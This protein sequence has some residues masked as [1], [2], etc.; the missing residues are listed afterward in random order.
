MN[1]TTKSRKVDRAAVA[2]NLASH[3]ICTAEALG[4]LL[5]WNA[6]R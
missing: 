2:F 4:E 1:Q 3:G 5:V 6:G